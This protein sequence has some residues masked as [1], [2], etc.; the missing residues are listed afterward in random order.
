MLAAL[1]HLGSCRE[2]V[3]AVVRPGRTVEPEPRLAAAY[4]EPLEQFRAALQERG[5]L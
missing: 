3:A 2:A 5:Y 4:A 1:P